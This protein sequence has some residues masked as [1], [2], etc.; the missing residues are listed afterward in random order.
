MHIHGFFCSIRRYGFAT[1]TGLQTILSH[2]PSLHATLYIL[3]D[4]ALLNCFADKI[5]IFSLWSVYSVAYS[6][7]LIPNF[8]FLY[9]SHIIGL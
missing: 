5:C 9:M 8:A 3:R 4:L 2:A 6:S 1:S 7:F